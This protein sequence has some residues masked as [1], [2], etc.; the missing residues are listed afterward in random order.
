MIRLG[1]L[2]AMVVLLA[3]PAPA[4]TAVTFNSLRNGSYRLTAPTDLTTRAGT[5][6]LLADLNRVGRAWVTSGNEGDLGQWLTANFG[7]FGIAGERV[8]KIVVLFPT[9]AREQAY[10]VTDPTAWILLLTDP[11]DEQPAI[12]FTV[13]RIQEE[14]PSSGSDDR[15]T[16]GDGGGG[17]G[18]Y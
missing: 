2:L 18:G 10:R 9:R 13:Q 4:W 12:A 7:K 5:E 3:I 17:G 11:A 6:G 15:D 16:D 1:L 14:Q 8:K